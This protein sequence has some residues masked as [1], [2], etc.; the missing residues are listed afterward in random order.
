[1]KEDA[2]YACVLHIT[3]GMTI[4]DLH[5]FFCGTLVYHHQD[6]DLLNHHCTRAWY[7]NPSPRQAQYQVKFFK[8][9]TDTS[10]WANEEQENIAHRVASRLLANEE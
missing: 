3:P 4:Y 6:R 9:W 1:M 7:T 10:N 2:H 5:C 8:F